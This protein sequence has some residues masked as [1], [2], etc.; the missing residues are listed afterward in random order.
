MKLPVRIVPPTLPRPF[1]A[2]ASGE[3]RGGKR[4]LSDAEVAL[5][6]ALEAL[7]DV[8]AALV[9]ALLAVQSTVRSAQA[10]ANPA[11]T[12]A[13]STSAG[14]G[15]VDLVRA[16]QPFLQ[17]FFDNR[18]R[19]IFVSRSW[20]VVYSICSHRSTAYSFLMHFSI[21]RPITEF[22]VLE[23]EVG[24][25]DLAGKQV[26]YFVFVKGHLVEVG[27]GHA[28]LLL[29]VARGLKRR[30]IRVRVRAAQHPDG[31]PLLDC[32]EAEFTSWSGS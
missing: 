22:G 5:V 7:K 16:A 28:L 6:T 29:R 30:H 18:D 23:A 12:S 8:H 3:A 1:G 14:S 15:E 24:R 10:V 17:D 13:G 9:A 25:A 31:E 11:W 21:L 4:A 26:F 20:L 19:K 27:Q 32:D 2:C